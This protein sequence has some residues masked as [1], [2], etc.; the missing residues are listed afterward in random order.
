VLLDRVEFTFIERR[1]FMLIFFFIMF[2][3]WGFLL[4]LYL[5]LSSKK[6][7]YYCS[8]RGLDCTGNR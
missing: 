8:P 7:K 5:A 2:W 1:P 3:N 6:F 4:Y